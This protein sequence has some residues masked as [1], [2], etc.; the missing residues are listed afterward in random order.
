MHRAC[1]VKLSGATVKYLECTHTQKLDFSSKVLGCLHWCCLFAYMCQIFFGSSNRS[2]TC[3]VICTHWVTGQSPKALF[4]MFIYIL[5]GTSESP[6]IWGLLDFT[7][8]IMTNQWQ[9][10][11]KLLCS[12]MPKC[13]RTE[14]NA[15]NGLGLWPWPSVC[16]DPYRVE[17]IAGNYTICRHFPYILISP[18]QAK[19]RTTT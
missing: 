13:L 17:F 12:P 5:Q 2:E 9:L 16:K 19:K 8:G 6:H 4:S 18:I 14:N 15:I 10:N 1:Y 3:D 7:V 11:F